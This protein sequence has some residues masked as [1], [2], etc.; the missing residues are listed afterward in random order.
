MTDFTPTLYLKE[1]CPFCLKVRIAV[2]E[3]GLQ[4]QVEIRQFTPGT[5][6][7]D[8]IRAELA[9][10]FEKITFPT[11]QLEPGVYIGDSDAIV[12]ALL[13]RA[14]VEKSSLQ[15]LDSYLNGAF[16]SMMGLYRENRELKAA[17]G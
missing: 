10:H 7:E 5:A 11:A 14:K 12:D 9:P 6:E 15:V 1:Y 3:A 13:A 4:D 17:A 8:A 2:I 16:K